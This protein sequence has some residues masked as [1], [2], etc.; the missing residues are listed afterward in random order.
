MAGSA[1][2]MPEIRLPWS[3]PGQETGPEA[4]SEL[5][6]VRVNLRFGDRP[7][8]TRAGMMPREY[9]DMLRRL[10]AETEASLGVP[11][12]LEARVRSEQG[13]GG[14]LTLAVSVRP[15]T[16]SL[17][18]SPR[19]TA[20]LE[21]LVEEAAR[22]PKLPATVENRQNERQRDEECTPA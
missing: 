9:V 16:E 8:E 22:L 17:R 18:P 1:E 13:T 4:R 15:I 19:A 2:N 3:E 14:R 21:E 7:V 12:R 20:G 10:Q 6:S 11:C 5:V